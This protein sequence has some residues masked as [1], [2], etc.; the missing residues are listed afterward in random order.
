MA[1]SNFISTVWSESL[2]T[3]L[4]KKYIGVSNCNRE[5]E[6]DIRNRGDR[7]KICGVGPVTVFNYTK[8]TDFTSGAETLSDSEKT[9]LIDQAKAF[10]FQIDDVDR[11]QSNPK[12]MNEAMRTAASA[13]A[14]A[15]D[16]Y[17]YSLYG[18]AGSTVENS[19]ATAS[20][21]LDTIIDARTKLLENNVNDPGDIVIEV[22]PAVA[23]LIFKGKLAYVG[24]EILDS[25]CI[26]S[27]AG[28]RVYVSNNIVVAV[29]SNKK[30]FHKCIARSKRA[31]AFAEQLSEVD[32][33]R[34]EKRFAD[35]VKGLHL[36]GAKVVYPS[37][38][39]LL[40]ISISA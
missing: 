13:L 22:S 20:N 14:G 26:G 38:M 19:A 6:G 1:I 35:A 31:V 16:A 5:Y 32:A 24:D 23:S 17:V 33:Y 30:N 3:A 2:L 37:E 34:P 25:G 4:D 29:D 15:A 36:Y 12:L 10:N 39:V 8:N 27:V 28:C 11:A 21:I 40:N 7:V 9:L 18:D